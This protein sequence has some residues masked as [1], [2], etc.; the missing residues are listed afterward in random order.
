MTQPRIFVGTMAS[1]EAEL[2][3]CRAAV[4]AQRG[5]VVHHHEIH[6]LRELEAHH[7]LWDAWN[8]AK[9]DFDLFAKIDADT[10]LV[11]DTALERVY[12]LFAADPQVTG[13]QILVHDYFTDGLIAGLNFF[14]PQVVFRHTTNRLRPDVVDTNHGRQLKHEAV[15]HLAPIA[16]HCRN[17][18]PLQA[19]HYGLHRA[20]KS[21]TDNLR[22]VAVAWLRDRDDARGWALTGAMTASFW[23]RRHFD[24]DDARF[25][26]AFARWEG[27]RRRSGKIEAYA[28]TLTK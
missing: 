14:H 11:D 8:A 28:G 22:L 10:I 4:K 2:D 23:M 5:V 25:H 16:W 18:Y 15:A 27:D 6:G 1:G 13:A 7:A 21:Q 17:P 3:A 9:A 24:Y 20:L 26:A 19:F 12:A